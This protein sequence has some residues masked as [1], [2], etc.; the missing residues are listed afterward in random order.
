MDKMTPELI[1]IIEA[2]LGRTPRGMIG[3][4]SM[5]PEGIPQVL[6]CLPIVEGKPF[7]TLYWLSCPRIHKIIAQIEAQQFI[8]TLE[9]EIIPNNQQLQID[10]LKA[11]KKY[12]WERLSLW[13]ESLSV[14]ED[15]FAKYLKV[16]ADTG[17]GGLSDLLRVRCLHMHYAHHLADYNPVGA[18][19]EK[20]FS[21]LFA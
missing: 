3:V 2:Q 1:K 14:R 6:K 9:N 21:S 11:H 13:D 18:L 20:E 8:K 15:D 19:I 7:P 16:I 4:A 10:L 12:Q 5:S 17:V